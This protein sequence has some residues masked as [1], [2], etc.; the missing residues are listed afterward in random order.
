MSTVPFCTVLVSTGLANQKPRNRDEFTS[1]RTMHINSIRSSTLLAVVLTVF[2]VLS[3][4]GAAEEINAKQ[5]V[6]ELRSGIG[7]LETAEARLKAFECKREIWMG[8]SKRSNSVSTITK[9]HENSLLVEINGI[10][11]VKNSTD[12]FAVTP[13]SM[14]LNWILSRYHKRGTADTWKALNIDS[15]FAICPLLAVSDTLSILNVLN[16]PTFGPKQARRVADNR[17]ELD[18]DLTLS[19]AGDSAGTPIV[20]GGTFTLATDLDWLAVR[21]VTRSAINS[22][23][24]IACTMTRDAVRDGDS[25]RVLAST[26]GCGSENDQYSRRSKYIYKQLPPDAVDPAEFTLAHYNLTAPEQDDVYE[27]RQPTNWILWGGIG[28]GCIVLSLILRWYVRRRT[29]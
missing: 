5:V 22:V 15:H 16:D 29:T 23:G 9:Y 21:S 12:Q 6:E 27:D 10:R 8:G 1:M 14:K 28:V 7:R 17:V 2:F 24:Q 25:I 4:R 3:G 18:Y 11:L 26:Y 13:T 19:P 20:M